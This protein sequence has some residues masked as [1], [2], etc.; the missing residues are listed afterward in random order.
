MWAK[1]AHVDAV[2]S[3]ETVTRGF[4]KSSREASGVS[5]GRGVFFPENF[6]EKFKFPRVRG[7]YKHNPKTPVG[8]GNPELRLR[9][10]SN[11]WVNSESNK[12]EKDERTRQKGGKVLSY[13][14]G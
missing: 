5:S 11:G 8:K 10:N 12:G 14:E 1:A 7:G 13:G 6:E 9:L 3:S 2:S 4:V